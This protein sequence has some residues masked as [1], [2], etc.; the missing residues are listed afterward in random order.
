MTTR[1]F[2][3]G[4]LC[5]KFVG[6]G[7]F[8]DHMNIRNNFYQIFFSQM[9]GN[10]QAG[11]PLFMLPPIITA[12]LKVLRTRPIWVFRR[13]QRSVKLLE[14]WFWVSAKLSLDSRSKKTYCRF[15]IL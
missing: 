4:P 13:A 7:A 5:G 14:D 9:F 3:K 8:S 10:V 12:K 1:P 11:P 6:S 2:Q 15:V